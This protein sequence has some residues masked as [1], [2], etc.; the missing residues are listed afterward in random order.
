[1]INEAKS[2]PLISGL[3]FLL[4]NNACE[5]TLTGIIF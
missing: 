2:N 1:M 3:L 4:K 5:L